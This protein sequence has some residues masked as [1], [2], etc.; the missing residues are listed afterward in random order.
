MNDRHLSEP[1]EV[2]LLDPAA[3]EEWA[4]L[5]SQF[6]LADGFWLAFVFGTSPRSVDVMRR[7]ACQMIAS[8]VQRAVVVE[9]R[10][11]EELTT[12]VVPRLLEPEAAESALIWVQA[13]ATDVPGGSRS[14]ERAWDQSLLRLNERRDA[15]RRHLRGGL[16]FALHSSM[17][18]L[19]RDAAP[20]LLSVGSL[21]VEV[22]S[23]GGRT[24]AK[25]WARRERVPGGAGGTVGMVGPRVTSR[26][27]GAHETRRL[28]DE[29]DSLLRQGQMDGAID[30]ARQAASALRAE[31]DREGLASALAQLSQAEE[32]DRD[33]AAAEE[34]ANQALALVPSDSQ[35]VG[36]L[37]KELHGDL[38]GAHDVRVQEL[39]LAR[40]LA[41]DGDSPETLGGLLSAHVSMGDSH[42]SRGGLA[43]AEAAY[44]EAAALRAGVP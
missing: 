16:V 13:V 40:R 20:D 31:R 2:D 43:A 38:T 25:P 26:T 7:R 34:H 12:A 30:K 44:S 23:A 9:P 35:L 5:R 42:A 32:A 15:V 33:V 27:A 4:R 41:R 8:R 37:L 10:Y 17:K 11:P 21:V 14:W 29:S 39:G 36:S 19:V 18:S 1:A 28:L 22:R 24:V 3:E 6:E